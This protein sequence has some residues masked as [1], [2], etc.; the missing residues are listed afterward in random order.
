VLEARSKVTLRPR[1]RLERIVES[2]ASAYGTPPRPDLDVLTQLTLLHL[3]GWGADAKRALVALAPLCG[4]SGAVDADKLAQTPRELVAS[5]CEAAAV[6]D[7]LSALHAAGA[8]ALRLPE[9]IDA[10]CRA[11]LAG[12]RALLSGLPGLGEPRVDLVLLHAGAHGVVAPSPFAMQAAVRLG[13]PGSTYAAVARALDVE[14]PNGD[15]D[16]AWRAHHVLD[17][18]GRS[19]CGRPPACARCPVR[20]GCAHGGEGDDPAARLATATTST[21]PTS[22]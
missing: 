9:G 18:H 8:L 20:D 4:R 7:A 6:D 16:L 13:Y 2:L 19:L 22:G 10:R 12:A 21:R 5:I 17:Q 1:S 3:V 11:D 15:V 14:L